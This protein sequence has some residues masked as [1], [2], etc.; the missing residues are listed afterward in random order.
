[1]DLRLPDRQKQVATALKKSLL[2]EEL[3]YP[4]LL[5]RQTRDHKE[6]TAL[7]GLYYFLNLL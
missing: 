2:H 4:Q 3:L 1:M 6:T 5:Q 7:Q